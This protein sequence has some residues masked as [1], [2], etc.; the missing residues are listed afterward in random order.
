MNDLW[1]LLPEGALL[2]L[3]GYVLSRVVP[4]DEMEPFQRAVVA[5]GLSL[6]L[7][8]LLLLWSTLAGLSWGSLA[9]WALILL[10]GLSALWMRQGLRG[11]WPG[12][13][14]WAKSRPQYPLLALV[15]AASLA[16]SLLAIR[17]LS[18][19]SWGDSL[20]H[21]WLARLVAERGQVPDSFYPYFPLDSLT[22]HFG[23]HAMVA[24]FHWATGL[25]V[26][27]S[28]LIF[29]QVLNALGVLTVYLLAHRLTHSHAAALLSALVVGL[30]STMPA[31]YVNWGRY[32]QL[33]GQVV[34]PVALFLAMEAVERRHWGYLA[35]AAVAASG[36]F[37]THYRVILFYAAFL[38]AYLGWRAWK[39]TSFRQVFADGAWMAGIGAAALAL[40][41]PRLWY[42]ALNLPRGEA[43]AP[44][45]PPEAW[46]QWMVS[47]NA[48]G[49][50]TFFLSWPLLILALAALALALRKKQGVGIILGGWVV[51]LFAMANAE[52]LGLGRGAW[53]NNFAVLI[54]LYLP[55]SILIGWLGGLVLPLVGRAWRAVP[56][57]LAGLAAAAGL[58]GGWGLANIADAQY[59]LVTPTDQRAIAWIRDNTPGD[60]RFLINYF[61]AYGGRYIVGSDGGWWIPYLAGREVNVPPLLYGAESSPDR[62]YAARVNALARSL[63]GD[64]FTREGLLLMREEG[65]T[66]IYIGEKGGFLDASKLLAAGHRPIYQD[67]PVWVFQVN[68]SGAGL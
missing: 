52:R 11:K 55:A 49:D 15:L 21:S 7:S 6:A 45:I 23:F 37:L 67:G 34:L 44:Q 26:T 24:F 20:H 59:V 3:P 62:D 29:G 32:T 30:V 50:I 46:E 31:Y 65:I 25:P 35:L 18:I 41:S 16:V 48:L 61:F 5:V 4:R 14:A 68:Y 53:L 12:L 13:V 60:A 27:E 64:L 47:Y 39:P 42:L 36:L 57:A 22:Y 54:F 9:T 17:D 58:W 10:S 56:Y 66:H 2:F 43:S 8:P 1:A 33:A 38:V 19:P 40:A 63:Q 28:L 51:L